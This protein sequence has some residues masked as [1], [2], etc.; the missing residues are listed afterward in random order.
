MMGGAEGAL[1]GP[2]GLRQGQRRGEG[3]AEVTPVR[4]SSSGLSRGCQRLWCPRPG[5]PPLPA[6]GPV[7][8]RDS[9]PPARRLEAESGKDRPIRFGIRAPMRFPPHFLDEIRARLSV[10]Q[11][12]GRKVALKRAGREFKG[13]SPFK[14]EKTPSFTVNDAEGLLPLLCFGRARRHLHL[15]DE[16]RGAVVPRGGRAAGGRG[17]RADAQARRAR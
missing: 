17:R 11:V 1:R 3:A 10:S 14:T 12:V 4:A 7:Q 16:D 6:F 2:D 13:L 15:R 5:F 9:D 8:S